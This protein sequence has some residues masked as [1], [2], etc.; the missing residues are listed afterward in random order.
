[1]NAPAPTKTLDPLSPADEKELA[2][3]NR[4]KD[5]LHI[6]PLSM[7]PLETATLKRA[8]LLKDAR[9]QGVV[10]LFRDQEG[11]SARLDPKR[12]SQYFNWPDEPVHP[13]IVMIRALRD[14]H[15]YDV[16]SLRIELRR[17]NISV[18]DHLSLRLSEEKNQELTKYMTEFTRPLMQQIYGKAQ[19]QIGDVGDLFKMF[20]NPNKEEAINNIKKMAEKLAIRMQ[21]VP[22]FLEDY[23][24]IFLSLAYF[25]DQLDIIVP[26]IIDFTDEL[27]SL[28][29][30]YQLRK[31]G[32]F[33]ETCDYIESSF[34]DITSS[35]T[36]RF[37]AFD[38]QSQNLW[39]N[40][41]AESFHQVRQMITAHHT[42]VGGVLCGLK[43]KMMAWN[44]KFRGDQG[45]PMARSDFIMS[46]IKQGIDLIV[47]IEKAAP[48]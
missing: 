7:I 25:K 4:E 28:K 30:N 12:L 13:D 33:V 37:E 18:N 31:D 47:K 6:L 22:V 20:S 21:D 41:T 42:T 40:I 5:S 15:S 9:L 44:E 39:E 1:M 48:A 16:F 24:D 46:D 14:L 38:R 27:H 3:R 8:R 34:N 36:G 35:I 45:G 43:V 11:G 2:Q 32:T 26:T 17:L 19:T 29:D 23:G 10:E